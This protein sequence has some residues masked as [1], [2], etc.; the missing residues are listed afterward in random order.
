MS[1]PAKIKLGD[2]GRPGHDCQ[3]YQIGV[4]RT[5]WDLDDTDRECVWDI[6]VDNNDGATPQYAGDA[7]RPRDDETA[8]PSYEQVTSV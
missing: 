5:E 3:M 4:L 7:R 1:E 8:I 6:T 2:C